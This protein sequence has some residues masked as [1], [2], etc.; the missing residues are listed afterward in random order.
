MGKQ[1]IEAL[2]YFVHP[3]YNV[4]YDND[5]ALIELSEPLKFSEYIKPVCLDNTVDP[6]PNEIL[7]QCGMGSD[8]KQFL[9]EEYSHFSHDILQDAPIQHINSSICQRDKSRICLG[10]VNHSSLPGD[11]GGPL[12]A[13]RDNQWIQIGICST[14]SEKKFEDESI[15]GHFLDYYMRVSYYCEWIKETTNNEVIC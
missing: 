14:G 7:T 4:A 12:M 13:I 3:K 1:K 6:Y 15:S 8:F 11:S 2:Q 5:V 10:G 9:K